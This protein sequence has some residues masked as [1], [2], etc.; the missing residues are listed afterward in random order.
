MKTTKTTFAIMAA[1]ASLLAASQA[2]AHAHLEMSNPAAN[3][4][5]AAPKKIML[6]FSEKLQPKF[7][8]F[9]VTMGGTAVPVKVTVAKD[10]VMG[11]PKKPLAAGAYAVKWHVVTADTHRMEGT[12]NFTVR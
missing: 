10:M 6:Q 5:V 1:A 3:A 7:S 2:W 12:F 4:T 8:G 11:T 9:E